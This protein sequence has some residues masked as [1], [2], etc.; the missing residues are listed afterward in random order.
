MDQHFRMIATN[1]IHL[2]AAVAGEGPLVVLVHGFPESWAAWRHQIGPI[3]AAG[4]KVVA[5]DLRGYG[6]S[7]K[8]DAI[9]AYDLESMTADIAGV[10]AAEGDGRPAILIGHDWGAALVWHTALVHE[11]QVRAVAALSVPF[12]GV[13]EAALIDILKPVHADRG[14]F[15]YQDYFQ[16]PGVAEAEAE[17]DLDR[18]VRRFYYWL[19]GDA[20][21]GL[22]DGRPA[23]STL[24]EGLPDVAPFPAWLGEEDIAYL[25]GEFARGG[26]RGPLNRYRNQHRDV[27]WLTPWRGRGIDQPALY[28]GGTRDIVLSM[29]PG[30]DLIAAMRASVPNL[31]EPVLLEGCGH[32]TQQE[33][34]DAVTD[35]L[36]AW[37][38]TLPKENDA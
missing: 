13:A 18:F 38:A 22:G 31:A 21:D 28:I 6:G 8:P 17:G 26:L 3:A 15:F 1:G 33:R 2:R 16:Q 14:R 34:P 4:Y 37:L 12:I 11:T 27:D 20:P 36:L 24:L 10:V 19:S 5:I 30:F 7:D 32:W 29:L 23:G 35:H 25:V 9:E